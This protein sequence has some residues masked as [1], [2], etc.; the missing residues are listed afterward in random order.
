MQTTKGPQA[1][2]DLPNPTLHNDLYLKSLHPLLPR[3]P[4][5]LGAQPHTLKHT[6]SALHQG[7]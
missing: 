2:P 4:E 1:D 3:Q 6:G 5:T 7:P